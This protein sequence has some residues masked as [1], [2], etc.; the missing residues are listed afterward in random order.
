MTGNIKV[1]LIVL[2]AVTATAKEFGSDYNYDE[3]MK[4][5]N[6]NFTGE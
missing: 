3:F 1:F 6:R 4:K 2:L 5:F